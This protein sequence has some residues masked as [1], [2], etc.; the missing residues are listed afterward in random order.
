MPDEKNKRFIKEYHLS[1]YDAEILTREKS[2]ADYF[3][4][5]VKIGE[6]QNLT[7]KQIANHIINRKVE[8]EKILP[9]ELIRI[10][11]SAT[12][13][14]SVSNDELDKIIDEVLKE[15]QKAIG[16]YKKGNE[17]VMMFLIGQVI[18]KMGKKIDTNI[19][20]CNIISKLK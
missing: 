12:Q 7:P 1:D 18:K 15:N 9:E 20:K 10:I 14:T 5:A 13:T 11:L 17:N 4:E 6:K 19:V 16:D 3:E 2:L 8:T